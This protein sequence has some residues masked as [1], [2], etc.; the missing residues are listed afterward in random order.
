MSNLTVDQL[1]KLC[2]EKGISGY[3]KLKK[4]ELVDLCIGKKKSPSQKPKSEP[5]IV[6]K[7]FVGKGA[8]GNVYKITLNNG[9]VFALKEIQKDKFK[10]DEIKLLEALSKMPYCHE[11][12]L[13]FVKKSEKKDVVE[14]WFE[15][16]KG[17]DL[18]KFVESEYNR[19]Y[20]LIESIFTQL[21]DVVNF[22]HKNGIVHRDLK[23]ANIMLDNGI[24]KLIDFG[25]SCKECPTSLAGT[26]IYEPPK[27]RKKFFIDKDRLS[28]QDF[29]IQDIFS[30]GYTM[31]V[32]LTRIKVPR[33]SSYSWKRESKEEFTIEYP[34][35]Q[36][37]D[38]LM[39]F[40]P[41]NWKHLAK[42]TAKILSQNY[43]TIDQVLSEWKK[44]KTTTAD[45]PKP[46]TMS[47]K[48]LNTNLIK[49]D[50]F[51]KEKQNRYTLKEL[52]S[53]AKSRGLKGYSN[54]NKNELMKM[55]N[56]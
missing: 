54:K 15:Y 45:V 56:L 40:V 9:Q 48:E 49:F 16:I 2:K 38:D 19:N 27:I 6:S 17:G 14:L 43:T 35:K 5:S 10:S 28:Y 7:E 47:V 3:S 8:F 53:M 55:L 46:K 36:T 31:L 24:V 1:K 23:P 44:L 20:F 22:L 13:C 32:L 11:H 21:L 29:K 26:P 25:L 41:T 4:A 52:K 33:K 30:I 34:Y 18:N 50:N 42:I 39:K 12:I 37:Y 51:L